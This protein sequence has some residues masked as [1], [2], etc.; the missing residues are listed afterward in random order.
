M[1]EK[2]RCQQRG[3]CYEKWKALRAT[4]GRILIAVHPSFHKSEE[5]SSVGLIQF[6][7]GDFRRR[8]LLKMIKTVKVHDYVSGKET[9]PGK[10]VLRIAVATRVKRRPCRVIGSKKYVARSGANGSTMM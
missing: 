4:D 8:V 2:H 7:S 6:D 9:V 3:N 10:K 5:A 1:V